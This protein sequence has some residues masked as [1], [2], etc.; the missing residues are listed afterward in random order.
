MVDEYLIQFLGENFANSNGDAAEKLPLWVDKNNA[1]YSAYNAINEIKQAKFRFIHGHSKERDYNKKSNFLVSKAEVATR[2][3]KTPQSIFHASAYS[4]HLSTY[5]DE[6]NETLL[7]AKNKKIEKKAHG[8]QHL[9][10]EELKTKTK[11]AVEELTAIKQYNCEELYARLLGN[12]PLDVKRK[13]G[14]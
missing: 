13:F 5:F 2:I 11:T 9:T 4:A 8:L 14:L 10:K 3:G 12:M 6:V 1:S 7:A